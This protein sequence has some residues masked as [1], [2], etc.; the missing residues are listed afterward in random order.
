MSQRL[1]ILLSAAVLLL[2]GCASGTFKA[3]Q[4]QR[5]KLAHSSG[6]YCEF[7]SGD[8]FPDVDVELSMQ[9]ARRCD[10]NKNYSITNYKNSSDQSGV[11]YCCSTAR[12]SASVA[13]KKPQTT[14]PKGDTTA[15]G[16]EIIAE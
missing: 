4:E 6:M 1:F 5:E 12:K 11:I 14:N 8:L 15:E 16:E 10:S 2:S 3:R 7:I 13:P 9:M